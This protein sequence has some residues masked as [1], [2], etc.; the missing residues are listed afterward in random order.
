[1]QMPVMDGLEATRVIR[2]EEA[3]S[4]RPRTP[5]LMLSANALPEHRLAGER[6]GADGH[7]A[8]PI[9]VAGLMG[10]LNAVLEPGETGEAEEPAA[11]VA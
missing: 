10:A 5:I 3:A 7:V 1:M 9:T 6:A 2:Q 4:G 11:A 8:K